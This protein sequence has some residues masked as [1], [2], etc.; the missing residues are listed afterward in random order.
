MASFYKTHN[1][2][3]VIKGS[4][5]IGSGS[6]ET[7]VTVDPSIVINKIYVSI[8]AEGPPVC[9]ADIDMVGAVQKDDHSFILYTNIKS[10][11]ATVYWLVEY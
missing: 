11:I 4:I 10:N 8:E 2:P 3:K 7:E 1:P 6:F 5:T 9:A